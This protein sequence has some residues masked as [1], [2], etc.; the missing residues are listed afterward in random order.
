MRRSPRKIVALLVLAVMSLNPILEVL[1]IDA[2]PPSMMDCQIM[3][4]AGSDAAQGTS[5]EAALGCVQHDACISHCQFA[6]LQL[7]SSQQ[8]RVGALLSLAIPDQPDN[9]VT[10]FLEVIERPPR[11]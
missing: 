1:A 8:M 10:R 11:V 6:P 2:A 5:T 3:V 7:S 9:F 4:A